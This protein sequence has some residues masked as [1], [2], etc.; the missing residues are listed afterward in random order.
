M[1]NYTIAA[2]STP[3]GVGA[4]GIVRMSGPA[5]KDILKKIWSNTQHPVDNFITRQLYYGK[6]VSDMNMVVDN[7]L[8]VI[9]RAPHSYTGED[10]VEIH[11]HGGNLPTKEVLKAL[12]SAG[13]RPAPAGEFTKRAFLNGRLDLAQAEGVA[14]VINANSSRAFRIAKEQLA[15]RLS[16]EIASLQDSLKEIK[17]FVEATIDFPEEDINFI[18]HG[19]ISKRLKPIRKRLGNLVTS[20]DEGRLIHDG[21]KVAIVGRPNVGK[22]SL[23]N[24]L[25]G[26]ERAI[27]HHIP[28]TT[29]DTVE[30]EAQI[31][32]INFRLI[33]TA[34]IRDTDCEVE[35]L[36]I[37]RSMNE[38]LQADLALVVLDVS[39]GLDSSDGKILEQTAAMKR[40][41]AL[42][43]ADLLDQKNDEETL[44]FDN[45]TKKLFVSAKTLDGISSLKTAL[46]DL[47]LGGHDIEGEVVIIT[48]LRHKLSL[49]KALLSFDDALNSID[50]KESAEFIALHLQSAMNELGKITG[51]IT[52]E[53]VLNEIFSKFCIGK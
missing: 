6:I 38:L 33:D 21:V 22:S 18:E 43:K 24:I 32:G 14:E 8:A 49:E 47:A 39:Q 28:G 35:Q 46:L 17:A 51:E 7:V 25:S 4:I 45:T 5:S 30:E 9:M 13:A 34:G 12:L 53:D 29:R 37:K 36:G 40:I 20:Y 50:K 48:N 1:Q 19:E 15:G 42:N 11:C 44:D 27:V 2:I 3:A 26:R 10:V 31:G 52:T 23:L 16:K 41:I